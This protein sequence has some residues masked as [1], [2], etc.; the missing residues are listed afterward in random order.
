M[1]AWGLL[2]T[3]PSPRAYY[4]NKEIA[5]TQIDTR[6][7]RLWAHE[8]CANLFNREFTYKLSKDTF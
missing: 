4:S 5:V 2:K 1:P 3:K 7:K 6:W 8:N